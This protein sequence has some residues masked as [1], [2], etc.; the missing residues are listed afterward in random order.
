MV[1]QEIKM[2]TIIC[3]HCGEDAGVNS[4][5]SCWNDENVALEQAM[6]ADWIVEDNK[7]YCPDCYSYDDN[8]KLVLKRI[9]IKKQKLV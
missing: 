4:D 1:V 8:D 7:N 6:Q 2:Y 5:Y 3:D 9:V